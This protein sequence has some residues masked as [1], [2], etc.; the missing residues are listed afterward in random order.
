MAD[1]D[2]NQLTQELNKLRKNDL[3]EIIIHKRLP[4]IHQGNEII[5][6]FLNNQD[7]NDI[8]METH[9]KQ[10]DMCHNS[11]CLKVADSLGNCKRELE[12]Q[13]KLINQLEG[14]V[15]DQILIVNLFKS[16]QKSEVTYMTNKRQ[17]NNDEVSNS[18][19]NDLSKSKQKS[20][21]ISNPQINNYK[22][23]NSEI[24]EISSFAVILNQSN[25]K[26]R[27]VK[28]LRK[29][30]KP[31]FDDKEKTKPTQNTENQEN[32]PK[33]HMYSYIERTN[34]SDDIHGLRAA[35]KRA[36]LFVGH[37]REDTLVKS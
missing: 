9:E 29:T 25:A 36:W 23:G 3:I 37:A 32:K 28:S 24:N 35:E 10:I 8:F 14:R 30:T 26:I 33:G 15:A 7:S 13:S 2:I 4:E 18:E 17:I 27:E 5:E 12:L 20:E 19:T 34:K 1:N 31:G 6:K 11:E 22:E 21:V 16:Q